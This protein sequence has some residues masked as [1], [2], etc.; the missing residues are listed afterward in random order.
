MS[1]LGSRIQERR[2]AAGLTV[3]ELAAKAGVRPH[4]LDL[5]ERNGAG[6]GKLL[7][8]RDVLQLTRA[9]GA[10]VEWL[11]TGK[12]QEPGAPVAE[13]TVFACGR[14]GKRADP[15]KE[16]GQPSVRQ[17]TFPLRG[18]KAGQCCPAQLCERCAVVIGNARL[19]APHAR[20]VNS[21]RLTGVPT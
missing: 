2:E 14:L 13:V 20:L 12:V 6:A 10:T 15:C 7:S 16:C 21:E 9:L 8:G 4:V 5:V 3:A 11:L 1:T 19:C 18:S 17:C